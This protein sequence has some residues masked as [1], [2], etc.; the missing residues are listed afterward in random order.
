MPR[1]YGQETYI[2]D[3]FFHKCTLLLY[4]VWYCTGVCYTRYIV[5]VLVS[6]SLSAWKIYD[7]TVYC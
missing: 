4:N 1:R 3:A 2:V 7:T 6:V 5:R